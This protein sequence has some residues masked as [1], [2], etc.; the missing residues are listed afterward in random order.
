MAQIGDM[1]PKQ[2]TH[3]RVKPQIPAGLLSAP[4]TWRLLISGCWLT[5]FNRIPLVLGFL[6]SVEDTQA[7]SPWEGSGDGEGGS[8]R[9]LDGCSRSG[10][11]IKSGID[12][13]SCKT[14]FDFTGH[15]Q[16]W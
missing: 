14:G 5:P 7:T 3:T 4:Y 15:F 13:T 8:C 6:C 16:L 2:D 1:S 11:G 10:V 9:G 12:D